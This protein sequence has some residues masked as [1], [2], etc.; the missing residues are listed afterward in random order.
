MKIQTSHD[1]DVVILE[2]DEGADERVDMH[3]Q[4]VDTQE[5]LFDAACLV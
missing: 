2:K 1:R 3:P 4:K 5:E